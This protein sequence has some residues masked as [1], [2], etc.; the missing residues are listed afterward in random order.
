MYIRLCLL[1]SLVT[2]SHLHALESGELIPVGEPGGIGPLATP[3]IVSYPLGAAQTVDDNQP[4]LFVRTTKYGIDTGLFM[5]EGAGYNDDGVPLFEAPV[6]VAY[7]AFSKNAYPPQG[8][9]FR[10]DDGTVHALFIQGMQ[11]AHCELELEPEPTF[12]QV[13]TLNIEGLPRAPHAVEIQWQSEPV[14]ALR[15]A[16]DLPIDTTEFKIWL[17]V[18]DGKPYRTIKGSS[19]APDYQPYKGDGTWH[20]DFPHAE[21]YSGTGKLGE[22]QST[23]KVQKSSA[24]WP[25][26]RHH[27][28]QLTTLYPSDDTHLPITIGGSRYGNL[29]AYPYIIKRRDSLIRD[30]D[31][32]VLRHPTID[33]HPVAYP[34]NEGTIQDLLVGGEGGIYSYQMNEAAFVQIVMVYDSPTYALQK[35]ATLYAGSLPVTNVVDWNGDGAKDIVAGN[36]EGLVYFFKNIG[37]NADPS[38]ANGTKIEANGEAI[39]IQPGYDGSIQGP[40]EARWGYVCPTVTDWNDDGLL[41]I[42]L[43]SSTADNLVYLNEGTQTNPK[44]AKGRPLY[45]EGLNLH[46]T[47]RNQPAIG[48]YRGWKRIITLDEEDIFHA[49]GQI[50]VYNVR[51]HGVLKLEDGSPINSN[52][53]E[54][55]GTGRLKI[56]L[57]NWDTDGINDL[58]VGTPRHAS[59]PNETEGLPQS[60]GLPGSSVLFLK[61]LENGRFAFPKLFTHKGAPIFLGQH[62]CGPAVADFGG[63]NGPDLIVGHESGRFYFFAREHLGLMDRESALA[64]VK[65]HGLGRR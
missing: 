53:L 17:G 4:E 13:G 60:L 26:P 59:I 27:F 61:G 64:Y 44:L 47:W 52:F 14:K 36:S 19:R 45:C 35:N 30:P 42:V 34:N 39:F 3:G 46:G 5:F 8:T 54:A 18:S 63:E 49:Y 58:I 33:P 55:G 20:G 51:D 65:K 48:E 25:T 12:K 6:K 50:D 40:G 2:C 9:I 32:L 29:H 10:T 37:S 15:E 38:F 62:A 11:L 31:K 28:G 23:I 43:S 22:D 1:F 56:I 7:P 41:D 24:G 57:Y 16:L 21:Y